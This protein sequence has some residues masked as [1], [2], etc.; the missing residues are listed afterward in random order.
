MTASSEVR[1]RSRVWGVGLVLAGLAL[2]V[3]SKHSQYL[4]FP[5]SPD[6]PLLAA[7]VGLLFLTGN[8]LA[9]GQLRW[10]WVHT[11]MVATVLWILWS[12]LSHQTLL[13][14]QGFFALLD[15]IIVPF[16]LFALAPLIFRTQADR[17]LL[18]KT[19]IPLGLYLG[20]TAIFEMIGPRVLVFPAYIADVRV[21]DVW[22]RARGP[23]LSA[24]ANG[25][26]LAASL[27]AALIGLR[28]FRGV[29]KAIAAL[30]LPICAVGV[31]LTLTRSVWLGTVVGVLAMALLTPS[32]R[33]RLPLIIAGGVAL[34]GAILMTLPSLTQLVVDRLTTQ[35]SVYDRANTNAAALRMVAD[36]PIDGVGWT[37]F[38]PLSA[39]WVRQS[40]T[41]PITHVA[42][43]V[44]NVVLGRAAEVGLVGAALWVGCVLAGPVLAVIRRPRDPA[45]EDWRLVL[46][47]FGCLWGI[48]I[49]LSP[50]PY[51]L[52]NNFLWLLAGLVLRDHLVTPPERETVELS[53]LGDESPDVLS[54]TRRATLAAS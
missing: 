5:V 27:F 38:M 23:L 17:R 2:S 9:A 33:R 10:R 50:V 24:E 6:R 31:L 25:M 11:F 13:D 12:A 49:M 29:W 34:V 47:G 20:L 41:Y 14:S 39:D 22:G 32:L 54:P 51:Q 42:I 3:L 48:A 46:I 30:T 18:I 1:S 15:R 7:G 35:R 45:L 4:G 21:G 19:L 43:E 44:H 8:L 52:P 28:H 26:I 36:H 16:V 37:R 53:A 40:D